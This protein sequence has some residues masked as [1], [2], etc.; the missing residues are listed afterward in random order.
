MAAC[1]LFCATNKSIISLFCVIKSIIEGFSS[2]S[3]TT[4]IE[5]EIKEQIFLC[6]CKDDKCLYFLP[7]AQ[8]Y[9][10]GFF[11]VISLAFISIVCFEVNK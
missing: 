10:F 7:Q 4:T 9:D 5:L 2:G 11:G 8:L 3:S 1:S 6:L